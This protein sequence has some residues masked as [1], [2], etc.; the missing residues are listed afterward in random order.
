MKHSTENWSDDKSENNALH[1]I[2]LCSNEVVDRELIMPRMRNK[3]STNAGKKGRSEQTKRK[4]TP[5]TTSHY[6]E[7]FA[8]FVTSG[9]K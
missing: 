3:T 9:I 4:K 2:N 7:F 1:C 6:K 8:E 5:H